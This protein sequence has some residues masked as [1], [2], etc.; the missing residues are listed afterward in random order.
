MVKSQERLGVEL[1]SNGVIPELNQ[2]TPSYSIEKGELIGPKIVQPLQ[3]KT[4]HIKPI[5]LG[6]GGGWSPVAIQTNNHYF[7]KKSKW[8]G[9]TI[10]YQ[11]EAKTNCWEGWN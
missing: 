4:P 8:C 7:I 9:G 6:G 2:E 11:T 10:S 1:D 5:E 3:D